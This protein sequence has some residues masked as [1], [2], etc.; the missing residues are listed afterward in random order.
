MMKKLLALAATALLSTSASAGYIQYNFYG[1][2]GPY[3]SGMSTLV[4]REEDKSVAFYRIETPGGTFRPRERAE[5]YHQSWLLETTTS[6][7]GLGPTNMYVRDIQ[8]EDYSSQ[9]WILFSEGATPDTFNYTMRVFSQ[10]GPQSPHP[11]TFPT[12]DVT[13]SGFVTQVPMDASLANTLDNYNTYVIP[14]DIPY[15]DPTQVPEPGSLALLAVGAL[16][17]VG[18]ARRRKKSA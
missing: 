11:E 7:I 3:N 12:R 4:I 16:S 13:Y 10:P 5:S 6:F 15:Y 1:A 9:M 8:L 17:A 2:T 14:R 18:V